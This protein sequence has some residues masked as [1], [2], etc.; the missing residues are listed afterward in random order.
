[1]AALANALKNDR[2][3]RYIAPQL[4]RSV[5]PLMRMEEFTASGGGR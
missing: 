2:L 3:Q 1:M 5:R 4:K